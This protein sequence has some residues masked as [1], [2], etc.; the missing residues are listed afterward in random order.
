MQLRTGKGRLWIWRGQRKSPSTKSTGE[1]LAFGGTAK[2]IRYLPASRSRM[3]TSPLVGGLH[4]QTHVPRPS[5]P[6]GCMEEGGKKD[7]K[8]P[9]ATLVRTEMWMSHRLN[10]SLYLSGGRR[11]KG[12]GKGCFLNREVTTKKSRVR[13]RFPPNRIWSSCLPAPAFQ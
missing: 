3:R 8:V 5:L 13:G 11:C 10:N 4:S 9:F 2:R 12:L 7:P 6:T 1:Y